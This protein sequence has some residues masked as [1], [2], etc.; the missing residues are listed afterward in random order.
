M[1]VNVRP[2][3]EELIHNISQRPG[4]KGRPI[5]ASIMKLFEVYQDDTGQGV[6]V[7]YWIPVIEKGRGPRRSNKDHGLVYKIHAWMKK[8]NMFRSKTPRGQFNE[9]RGL[10]WYINKYGTEHFR[11]GVFVDVYHAERDRTVEKIYGKYMQA[12]V[13]ILMDSL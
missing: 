6:L 2:E 12:A 1:L 11:S 4:Y 8:R 3:L 5:P 9:A 10:T 7:P 13:K